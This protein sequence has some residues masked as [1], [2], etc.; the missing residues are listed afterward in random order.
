M[1][2]KE[3]MGGQKVTLAS[4]N[5]CPSGLCGRPVELS[6]LLFEFVLGTEKT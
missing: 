6:F 4:V 2:T 3:E 1:A 5:D